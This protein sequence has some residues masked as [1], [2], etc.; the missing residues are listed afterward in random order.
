VG[1]EPAEGVRVLVDDGDRVAAVLDHL[2]QGR[3]GPAAT[4]DH[5]VH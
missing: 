1:P 5:E 3:A 2:R 4:H